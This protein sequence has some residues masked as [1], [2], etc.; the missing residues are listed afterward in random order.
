MDTPTEKAEHPDAAALKG[1]RDAR[2]E[3]LKALTPADRLRRLDALIRQATAVRDA[4][5]RSR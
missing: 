2:E 1:A 4:A 3:Q 5:A